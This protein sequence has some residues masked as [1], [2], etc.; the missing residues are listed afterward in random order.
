M[1]NAHHTARVTIGIWIG[2][3]ALHC[4]ALHALLLLLPG[5]RRP[6]AIRMASSHTHYILHCTALHCTALHCTA[7][8]CTAHTIFG[9]GAG[10]AFKSLSSLQVSRPLQAMG[11]QQVQCS[12]VQCSAV[13]PVH[14]LRTE[15]SVNRPDRVILVRLVPSVMVGHLRN[16][17]LKCLIY[18]VFKPFSLWLWPTYKLKSIGQ[19]PRFVG[20]QW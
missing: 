17:F 15:D 20:C 4:T 13:P 2:P 18:C 10:I 12:A 19:P 1:H 7:L 5:T 11:A 3:T 6:P 8:H 16:F 9:A 14:L